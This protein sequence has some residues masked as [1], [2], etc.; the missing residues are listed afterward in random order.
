MA[1]NKLGRE[2]VNIENLKKR[3]ENLIGKYKLPAFEELAEEFDVERIDK[4]SSF[5][6]RDIRRSVNEKLAAYLH[7]F[8]TF[9]NPS[10]GPMF[11]FSMMKNTGDSE[12]KEINEL[13]KSIAKA[14]IEVFKLDTI[15]SEEKEADFIKNSFKLWVGMKTKVYALIDKMGSNIDNNL[16]AGSRGYFG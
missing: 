14:Q 6:L 2:C 13:Y 8:E 10:S 4:E 9:L 11:V 16:V 5:V 1:E 15:Y 3:Y 7:L 12:R